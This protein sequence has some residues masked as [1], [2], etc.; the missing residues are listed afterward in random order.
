MDY[1][2]DQ[3]EETLR[4]ILNTVLSHCMKSED[5]DSS[6]FCDVVQENFGAHKCTDKNAEYKCASKCSDKMTCIDKK[7]G[8]T[9]ADK[10]S[11]RPNCVCKK[12]FFFD[13]RTKSCSQQWVRPPCIDE[14]DD[15]KCQKNEWKCQSTCQRKSFFYFVYSFFLLKFKK[16][17]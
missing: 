5:P 12:G 16:S 11:K 6:L 13:D 4:G 9:C 1:C 17:V 2:Q 15:C 8:K 14:L 3:S 10:E 7:N